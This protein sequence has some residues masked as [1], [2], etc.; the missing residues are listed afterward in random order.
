[1]K[2]AVMGTG[3]MGKALG[4]L[5]AANGHEVMFGSRDAARGAA[6]ASE[7]GHGAS[8]GTVVA[9]A[10]FCD[11]A[12]L[13]IPW[14]AFTDFERAVGEALDYK[15]V[16][17]CIN[18]LR[19]TGSLA[20]GHKWSAGEEVQKVL[21]R[22]RVVKA[23]NHL[24]ASSLADATYDGVVASAF[25]CSNFDDAKAAV[26]QLANE[27]GYEPIDAG[28]I[29]NARLLEPMAA[30]WTQLAFVTHHGPNSAFKLVTR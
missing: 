22:C 18:P 17:D 20:I 16:I 2:I 27:M 19:S 25:Y 28:P 30:L 8:G 26:V 10:E 29:K 13:A 12:V 4:R 11:V 14:F 5:L 24:Y 15:V 1:M 23:F 7:I 9:S 21:H 3:R 6:T